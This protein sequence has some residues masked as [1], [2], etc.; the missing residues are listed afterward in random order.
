MLG[1]II[2][3]V[4][5]P[6]FEWHNYKGKDFELLAPYCRPTDDSVMTAAVARAILD[7][8]GTFDSL[9]AHAVER[10]QEHGRMYPHAGCGGAFRRWLASEDPQPYHS[11]GNGAGMRVSVID[12]HNEDYRCLRF[13]GSFNL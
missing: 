7:C 4:V 3:D 11:W 8:N 10:M 6:R 12:V 13:S 9:S 1:A 5:G 2:G